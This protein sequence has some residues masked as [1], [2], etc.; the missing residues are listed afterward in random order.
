[1]NIAWITAPLIGATIGGVTN[2]IAIKML[3]HPRKAVVIAG[4]RLPFTPG[5]IPKEQRRIAVSLSEA[6]ATKLLSSDTI[7]EVLLSDSILEK[8]DG[9]IGDFI[10]E[11][12]EKNHSIEELILSY[13]TQESCNVWE[14]RISD[15]LAL[16]IKDTLKEQGLDQILTAYAIEKCND[17]SMRLILPM[18]RGSIEGIISEAVNGF[19]EERL[20]P[21]VKLVTVNKLHDLK[22]VRIGELMEKNQE[23][24]SSIKE[25]LRKVYLQVIEKQIDSI[26][27]MIDIKGIIREKVAS[28]EV[29][30]LESLILNIVSKEL[31]AIVY[32]GIIIG[33]VIGFLNLLV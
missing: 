15:G 9:K 28:F 2:W 23:A 13:T 26:L 17:S 30:E 20:E 25:V 22:K 32:L 29:R 4:K 5:V 19:I 31:N 7:R 10:D 16:I 27:D 14:D 21:I 11:S 8:L 1:M 3:F 6:I 24:I 33:M 18:I 12:R